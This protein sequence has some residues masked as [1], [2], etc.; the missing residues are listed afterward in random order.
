MARHSGLPAL[1]RFGGVPL[2]MRQ[3]HAC[4]EADKAVFGERKLSTK[5][6]GMLKRPGL[7]SSGFDHANARHNFPGEVVVALVLPMSLL[8]PLPGFEDDPCLSVISERA[9]RAMRPLSFT[10]VT[11]ER[12]WLRDALLL[13]PSS[14]ARSYALTAAKD[15]PGGGGRSALRFGGGG[16]RSQQAWDEKYNHLWLHKFPDRPAVEPVKPRTVE[17]YLVT[18]KQLRDDARSRGLTPLFHYTAP[19][20]AGLVLTGGLRM[21]T[22]GQGDGGVYF[23]TLSPASY[24][25]GK[26]LRTPLFFRNCS[27]FYLFKAFLILYPVFGH[28]GW[29]SIAEP[30]LPC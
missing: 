2:T 18:M 8:E 10:A 3:P 24:G 27:E 11:D 12:P 25:L 5:A 13:P 30:A 19:H 29:A 14:I 9:L 4:T 21:S 20:V 6:Q 26:V 22:Q 15:A 7:A 28:C 17:E 16:K 23:S 1:A